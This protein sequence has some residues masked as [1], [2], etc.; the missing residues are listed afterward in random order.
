[1]EKELMPWEEAAQELM[2]WEEAALYAKPLDIVVRHNFDKTGKYPE[3]M[4]I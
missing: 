1:M 3:W 4:E 2:P